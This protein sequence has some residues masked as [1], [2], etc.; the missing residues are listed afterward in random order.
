[1]TYAYPP[2]HRL[3]LTNNIL[4]NFFNKDE[5]GLFAIGDYDIF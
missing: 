4:P 2:E 3:L 5:P 1:M